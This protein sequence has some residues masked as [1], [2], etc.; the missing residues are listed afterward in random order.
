MCDWEQPGNVR[1]GNVWAAIFCEEGDKAVA[2]ESDK[3]V[4]SG[5]TDKNVAQLDVAQLTSEA[6][7]NGNSISL[8]CR[9]ISEALAMPM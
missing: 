9:G 2:Q 5:T 3:A 8:A 1:L 6:L 4:A 7:D